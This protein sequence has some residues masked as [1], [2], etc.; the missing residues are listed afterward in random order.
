[1][2]PLHGRVG[3]SSL[4]YSFQGWLCLKVYKYFVT[5]EDLIHLFLFHNCGKTPQMLFS[6]LFLY[7]NSL[8]MWASGLGN[9]MKVLDG[10]ATLAPNL[11]NSYKTFTFEFEILWTIIILIIEAFFN[12]VLELKD[13]KKGKQSVSC[14]NTIKTGDKKFS[15]Q[16]H[17]VIH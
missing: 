16:M 11:W 3:V 14:T 2:K 17:V 6:G 5:T 10:L 12:E 15:G 7:F 1:M 9:R 4:F 8:F 13:K